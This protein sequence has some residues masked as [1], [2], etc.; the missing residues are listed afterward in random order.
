M[1][2]SILMVILAI[3]V[4]LLAQQ[5]TNLG[6]SSFQLN[7]EINEREIKALEDEIF[8]VFEASEKFNI[9]DRSKP[10]EELKAEL[11]QLKEESNLDN[12]SAPQPGQAQGAVFLLVGEFNGFGK[13]DDYTNEREDRRTGV[14]V[15]TRVLSVGM[16]FSLSMIDVATG[17]LVLVKSYNSS[18]FYRF[19]PGQPEFIAPAQGFEK[20]LREKAIANASY[21][22]KKFLDEFA[23]P[24]LVLSKVTKGND[25][26]VRKF[27]ME[28]DADVWGALRMDVY[29]LEAY[30]INGK[31]EYRKAI[32]GEA[33]AKKR[34]Y[35]GLRAGKI[36]KGKKAVKKALNDN[37]V[38]YFRENNRSR[39]LLVGFFLLPLRIFGPLSTPDD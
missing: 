1:K 9:L 3:P 2:L 21:Y 20:R 32:I 38:V 39:N 33:K 28:G 37:Q 23:K 31:T 14:T 17:E 5:K 35:P 16:E 8:E 18:G 13:V 15:I 27:Q 25:E 34:L 36:V 22:A 26:K 29:V 19:S 7:S 12:P 30:E 24:Q 6:I 10:M 11:E 4:C